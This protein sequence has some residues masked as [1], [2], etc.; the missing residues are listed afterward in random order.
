M[1]EGRKE[2]R[3]KEHLLL[4]EVKTDVFKYECI[5]VVQDCITKKVGRH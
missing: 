5:M 3:K 1:N 2:G 4:C